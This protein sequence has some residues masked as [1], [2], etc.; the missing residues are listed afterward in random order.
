MRWATV[1]DEG[2]SLSLGNLS[3]DRG[4]LG[5]P[6]VFIGRSVLPL[7]LLPSHSSALRTVLC[8]HPSPSHLV[9][10]RSCG[11][12][13]FM[14]AR[15]VSLST[16]V[17]S[18]SESV[19]RRTQDLRIC[20]RATTPRTQGLSVFTTLTPK[21]IYR[22]LNTP[23]RRKNTQEYRSEKSAVTACETSPSSQAQAREG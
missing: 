8:N 19:A 22:S 20:A 16:R 18:F 9:V 6:A 10:T 1:L 14:H 3:S 2:V 7:Y 23:E 15:A 13:S 11:S 21:S 17:R 4:A 12:S 5:S